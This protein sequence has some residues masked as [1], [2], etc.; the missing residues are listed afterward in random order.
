MGLG[1]SVPKIGVGILGSD[2]WVPKDF[3][4]TASAAEN[5]TALND[6]LTNHR[7]VYISTPGVYEIDGTIWIP[8]NT[9]L[10]FVAG[11]TIK[12]TGVKTTYTHVF[13]NK[14]ILT[15]SRNSNISLIGNGL[16]FDINGVDD[17]SFS[18]AYRMRGQINF[19]KVDVLNVKGVECTNGGANQYFGHFC[20]IN[21]FLLE[22]VSTS[23][24]K[25]GLHFLGKCRN[26]VLRNIYT[27]TADDSIAFLTSDYTSVTPD[28][29]DI[30]NILIENW[31][32][33]DTLFPGVGSAMMVVPNSWA[34][35]ATSTDY[36]LGDKCTNAGNVYLKTTATTQTS[37][38]APVHTSGAVT[39]ADGLGWTWM[40]AGT[41]TSASIR[42]ITVRNAQFNG[43]DG[44][45]VNFDVP[46]DTN[47]RAIFPGT[48]G[49][50][51]IDN[52]TFDNI[53]WTGISTGVLFYG[54]NVIKKISLINSTITP[55]DGAKVFYSNAAV[56]VGTQLDEVIIDN[57]NITLESTS[58]LV[59]KEYPSIGRLVTISDSN[60]ILHG[61]SLLRLVT[62]S[63]GE[64]IDI[65]LD[66]TVID[67]MLDLVQIGAGA[68]YDFDFSITNSSFPSAASI[69]NLTQA[70]STLNYISDGCTYSDPTAYLWHGTQSGITIDVQNSTGAINQAKIVDANVVVTACDL[71]IPAFV[72]S[73]CGN[74]GLN[75]LCID[76]GLILDGTSIPDISAFA[77]SDKT[78]SSVAISG[79][80]V[81]LTTSANFISTDV[82]TVSY[83]QP[84]TNKLRGSLLGLVASFGATSVLNVTNNLLTNG[85]FLAGTGSWTLNY[86]N[87]SVADGIAIMDDNNTSLAIISNGTYTP[88]LVSH[89]I[90]VKV[91]ENLS[92]KALDIGFSTDGISGKG[93]ATIANCPLGINHVT[94]TALSGATRTY[95]FPQL[96]GIANKFKVDFVVVRT[97]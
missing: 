59:Y 22:D 50:A 49:N 47:M 32:N 29:G 20:D 9:E 68:V 56:A 79:K 63:G 84:T 14:G 48:M 38:N 78:V 52:F 96:V 15:L 54:S 51:Y 36:K 58:L 70:G 77:V 23:G 76:F 83:T 85:N 40:H 26:G 60:I 24:A 66:N 81:I 45:I 71:F 62:L 34:N 31:E 92:N 18:S 97:T 72:S 94:V 87:L 91:K 3:L 57:C 74:E 1:I 5:V 67:G 44:R 21:N 35:W 80:Q 73:D 69:L 7:K 17:Y 13:A 89:E 55:V 75:K 43:A 28:V 11:C 46:D 64:H 90:Y 6:A 86:G 93:I 41:E 10:K 65:S 19:W 82:V 95:M 88:A 33:N 53:T 25:D 61:Q 39:G 30:E 37:G 27:D 2:Y 4:T 42:N 16:M 8:S 12:K